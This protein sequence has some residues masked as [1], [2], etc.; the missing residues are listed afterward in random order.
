MEKI[1]KSKLEDF[2]KG[3]QEKRKYPKGFQLS[4]SSNQIGAEKLKALATAL[5][6]RQC[7]Q[8]LQIELY[9]NEIGD[10]EAK[11]PATPILAKMM[12]ISAK[13]FYQHYVFFKF[14]G[15]SP[16]ANE[17]VQAIK[18]ALT[19][20]SIIKRA[21]NIKIALE[22]FLQEELRTLGPEKLV[23]SPT[24]TLLNKYHLIASNRVHLAALPSQCYLDKS[25]NQ[26]LL[27]K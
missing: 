8:G 27:K 3:I 16:Q 4:L 24:V 7:P 12:E 22:N 14:P 17:L 26:S 2:L 10:E 6:T 15:K 5:R 23:Q 13:V 1:Y 9:D 25:D 11:V 20:K 18:T 21:A 19:T